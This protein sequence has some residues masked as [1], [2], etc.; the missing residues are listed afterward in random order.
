MSRSAR[1][2]AYRPRTPA[3]KERRLALKVIRGDEQCRLRYEVLKAEMAAAGWTIGKI[4]DLDEKFAL[5]PVRRYE[6]L[7]A[8]VERWEALW[9]I[10]KR[11]LQTRAKIIIA[12]AVLAEMAARQASGGPDDGFAARLTDLLDRLVSR[13]SDRAALRDLTGLALP[14]RP[15]GDL[16]ETYEQAL[17]AIGEHVPDDRG[18]GAP[19]TA[20]I[21]RSLKDG[22]IVLGRDNTHFE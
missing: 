15:G 1:T 11:K 20:A 21:R 13:V 22:L 14:L 19:A 6:V 7:K 18:F 12:A 10:R 16:D 2:W 8:R 5:D 9:S 17:K 4:K 3:Q